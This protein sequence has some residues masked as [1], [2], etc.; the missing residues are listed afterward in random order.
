MTDF[1][2]A[3]DIPLQ[4]DVNFCLYYFATVPH[5]FSVG[6][7]RVSKETYQ[8]SYVYSCNNN[9][10]PMQGYQIAF[11][12]DMSPVGIYYNKED[13]SMLQTFTSVSA[14]VAG[15]YVVMSIVKRF[16]DKYY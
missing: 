6:K 16:L 7:E 12:F 5:M 10:M 15:V 9:P 14:I 11:V 3:D 4:K 2:K 13:W 8:Y 1:N